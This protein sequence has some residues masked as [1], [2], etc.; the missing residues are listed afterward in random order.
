MS[1]KR[2]G[3]SSCTNTARGVGTRYDRVGKSYQDLNAPSTH[4]AFSYC[5][6]LA[7][8]LLQMYAT[9]RAGGQQEREPALS[10]LVSSCN[11][12]AVQPV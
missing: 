3:K 7:G 1:F 11:S 5:S 6:Q 9:A 12:N 8:R 10:I 2:T 4:S